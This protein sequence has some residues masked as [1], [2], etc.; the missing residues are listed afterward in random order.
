MLITKLTGTTYINNN[1]CCFHVKNRI[2]QNS[3]TTSSFNRYVDLIKRDITSFFFFSHVAI[4]EC[5][6]HGPR[7]TNHFCYCLNKKSTKAPDTRNR[8]RKKDK[9]LMTE[10]DAVV[11]ILLSTENWYTHIVRRFGRWWYSSAIVHFYEVVI[12]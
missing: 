5:T 11:F 4:I 1:F 9:E 10:D 6:S 7:Y 12:V 3:R 8:T 2:P